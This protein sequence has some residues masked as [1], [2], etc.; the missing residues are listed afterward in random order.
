MDCGIFRPPYGNHFYGLFDFTS[1]SHLHPPSDE[2][3][4]KVTLFGLEFI[5]G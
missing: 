3:K 4:I 5:K 1:S 2:K